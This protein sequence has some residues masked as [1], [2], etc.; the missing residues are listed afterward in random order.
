MINNR[1]NQTEPNKRMGFSEVDK[2]VVPTR[3]VKLK[4]KAAE[5]LEQERVQKEEYKKRFEEQADKTIQ[6]YREKDTKAIDTISRFIKMAGE[7]TL[8]SNK[9]GIAIDV[10]REI[11]QELIQLAIDLNNDENEEDNGK[12]SVVVL[13]AIIKVMLM[14]RDRINQLEFDIHQLKRDGNKK[15]LSSRATQQTSDANRE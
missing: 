13:S 14:Y 3:G 7:K 1:F 6:H 5:K 15:D 11:R 9:G 4:N 8:A 12:G 2:E 10:E